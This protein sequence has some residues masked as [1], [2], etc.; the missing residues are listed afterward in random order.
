MKEQEKKDEKRQ[1]ENEIRESLKN[2]ILS[3][4]S[5][6]H[7]D[8]PDSARKQKSFRIK[9]GSFLKTDK[10]PILRNQEQQNVLI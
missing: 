10:E 7:Q 5:H 2:Q 4:I 9:K 6:E 3:K 1:K 8:E